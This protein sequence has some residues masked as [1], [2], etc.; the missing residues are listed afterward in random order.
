MK[1]A[2]TISF[3]PIKELLFNFWATA[4]VVPATSANDTKYEYVSG[5]LPSKSDPSKSDPSKL[6]LFNFTIREFKDVLKF[7][8]RPADTKVY[9][10]LP[11]DE[12]L[13]SF[14]DEI[15]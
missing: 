14:L 12:E 8:S 15:N 3:P 9:E 5:F 2:L 7:P 10:D 6:E 1:K 4:L 11:S 13:I